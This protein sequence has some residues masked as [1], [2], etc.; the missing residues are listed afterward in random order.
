VSALRSVCVFSGSSPGA[1]PSYAETAT[2]LGREVAVRGMRLVYGGASVGLMG[3]VADAALA[4]GGEVVGVIPQHLVDREVAHDGLTELR[5][6]GS[7]HERKALMA[8]LAD[9]FVALPGGLGTLEEL[10][11]ILTWS[12]LGLQ[13]KPCGLLDVEGFFDPLLAFLDH[14]VAERFV[15]TEHRA[16][17]LA[18]DRPDALL[19]L[20]SAWQPGGP[21]VK[22]VDR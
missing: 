15:S 19:D 14:T 22:W 20:L 16:L 18:A 3:A 12:Q 13:S 11:E 4:A 2:A 8:D 10:A 7:M 9:G 17:V 5:V 1:R 21:G 6:T